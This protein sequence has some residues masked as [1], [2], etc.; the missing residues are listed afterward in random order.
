MEGAISLKEY[1]KERFDVQS[2][3]LKEIKEHV[4]HTNGRVKKLEIGWAMLA[5]GWT[6]LIIIIIPIGLNMLGK[7]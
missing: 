3:E 1:L 6:V 4:K 5:G 7:R 2:E